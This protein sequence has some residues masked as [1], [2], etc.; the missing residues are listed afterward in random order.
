MSSY[1]LPPS[2]IIKHE[3]LPAPLPPSPLRDEVICEGSHVKLKYL[4]FHHM[5]IF[6]FNVFFIVISRDYFSFTQVNKYFVNASY[7]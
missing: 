6:I 2:P 4:F 5:S 3:H 7:F 1:H